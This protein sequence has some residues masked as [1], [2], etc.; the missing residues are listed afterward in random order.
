LR[1]RA[2]VRV[3]GR[4]QGV[5]FRQNTAMMASKLGVVGHIRN[6]DDGSVEAIFEGEKKA[7]DEI[8]EWTKRGPIHARVE[9]T[10]VEWEPPTGEFDGFTIRH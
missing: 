7:V 9:R 4:V 6:L 10:L 3:F 5:L 1:V 8:V 2:S